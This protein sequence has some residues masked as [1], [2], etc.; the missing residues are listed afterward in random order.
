M[1][2]AQYNFNALQ[3]EVEEGKV[4]MT[5]LGRKIMSVAQEF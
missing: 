4:S 1:V 2:D 3:T 5:D